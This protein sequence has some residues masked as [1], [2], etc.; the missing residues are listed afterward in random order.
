MDTKVLVTEPAAATSTTT[1]QEWRGPV[2]DVVRELLAG[3]ER[4]NE[5]LEIFSKLVS[6]NSELELQLAQML[7]RRNNGEGVST[8][9]LLLFLSQAQPTGNETKPETVWTGCSPAADQANNDL[10]TA[11]GIDQKCSEADQETPSKPP[12]QPSVRKPFPDHLRRQEDVIAVPA[13]LRIC[14]LC[15]KDRECIGHDVVEL[16]DLKPAEVFVRVEMREKLQCKP[17]DGEIVRAPVGDRMV[18]GG[19]FGSTLVGQLLVDKYDDGLPLHR[20]KQRFE[21][22]GLPVAVSTLAD[23]VQ[24]VTELL[25]VLWR[26]ARRQVLA[27]LVL[28]VDG[29]G[30]PVL[31]R[32]PKTHKKIGT[33]KKLG[34]LW[35]YVGGGT[36]LYLYCSSGHK[37]GQTE[38]D[39]GPEDFLA[40]RVGFTVADAASVFDASFEREGLI[41]CGCNM[42]ARRYFF[43]ALDGGDQRAALPIA[44]FKKLYEIEDGIRELD[45]DE[46]LA[47]R[48]RDSRLVYDSLVRWCK[49]YQNEERPSSP[50]GKAV[51]Y[52]LNHELA[53]TR[54][55]AH[56]CVPIDNGVVE[57]LHVRA[58][59]TRKNFLFAGSDAGVRR[60]AIAYTILSSCRLAGVNPLEYLADVLPILARGG[61]RPADAAALLP[62]AWRDARAAR[63][64][65]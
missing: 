38:H 61:V 19:R 46:R 24:W 34:T 27:A 55:L 9:Q 25:E 3:H 20:Q 23:Q 6:R 53:L 40:E 52:L 56:G 39:I 37:Q 13:E 48:K 58:A 57:R 5:L 12:P 26:A 30:L 49:V 31:L 60:A 22:M 36:A 33:G 50:L 28:H 18:S 43:K 32:D 59:L 63:P 65:E 44:A 51:Q 4:S 21:R 15:G 29:T 62:A 11:S 17:C 54:F 2:L 10:R 35:G 1:T 8:A 16:A 45:D 7:S 42:H 41:E 47:V 64:T 14:P